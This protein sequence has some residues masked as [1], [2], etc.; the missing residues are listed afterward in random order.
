LSIAVPTGWT[1][2]VSGSKETARTFAE[3]VAP[4]ATVSA[5]FKVTSGSAAFNGDLVAN[6]APG[7]EVPVDG[8][9]VFTSPKAELSLGDSTVPAVHVKK[10]KA[11]YK[12]Q[13]RSGKLSEET[14]RQL[15]PHRKRAAAR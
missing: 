15:E 10:L 11:Q 2:V 14:R 9:V 4:G 1:S 3:A 12:G 6:A 13:A 7:V 5:T 8:Q